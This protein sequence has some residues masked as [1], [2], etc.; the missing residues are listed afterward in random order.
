MS[1]KT[2]FI[3]ILIFQLFYLLGFSQEKAKT[4]YEND[5]Y[6]KLNLSLNGQVEYLRETT[7][8]FFTEN[9]EEIEY[10]FD[11]NGRPTQIIET[12]LGLDV[13]ARELRNENTIFTFENGILISELNQVDEGLDGYTY[14]INDA[15]YIIL[16]KFYVKNRLVSEEVF[17][18]DLNNR[19]IKSI[20]YVYGFFRDFTGDTP[21][22]KDGFIS[23]IETFEYDEDGNLMEDTM[24]NV[25]GDIFKKHIFIFDTNGN[26][27]EDGRCKNYD[28][29]LDKKKCEYIPSTGYQYNQNNQMIKK[30]SIG[31]W[32]PH[33]TDTYYKYD[34]NGR[35][36]EAKGFYITKKDTVLGYHYIYQY[37][38][39]G[40][41]TKEV[42]IV[43]RYRSIGFDKYK[44]ESIEYDKF[45]NITLQEFITLDGQRIK[46]VRYNYVYDDKGNWIERQKMEGKTSSDLEL[47]ERK[48]KEIKYYN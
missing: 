40:N 18:Y 37:D 25:K 1:I 4:H 12:S 36:I 8:N 32:S 7:E 5:K 20:D 26:L 29:L 27:V 48:T 35:E 46:V 34:N 22:N 28:K 6:S 38:N 47:T 13:M 23:M 9:N 33:N 10:Y 30:Y 42:E 24:N 21:E 16:E 14:T 2:N 19:L 15:G 39:N 11:K 3:L 17:D 31:D 44:T 43:G 41:K 45:Q